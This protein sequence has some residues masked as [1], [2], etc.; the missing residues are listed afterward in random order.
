M[1]R[2]IKTFAVLLVAVIALFSFSV[3]AGATEVS[4]SQDGLV[5]S[6]ISAKD[7]Y[8]SNENIE[9]VFQVT[10]T[11]DFDVENVSLEAIIPDGLTL[12]SK[13]D[14]S[15]KT[16]SLKSG[17]SLKLDLIVVKENSVIVAPIET[18]APSV[19]STTVTQTESVQTATAKA[20]SNVSD[21]D[22]G[23][24]TDNTSIKTGSNMSCWLA[25]LICLVSLAVAV[26]AFRFRK[27]AVKYLSL[28]L[29]VCISVSTVAVVSVTNTMAEETKQRMSFEVSKTFTV[30]NVNYELKSVIS[31][32]VTIDLSTYEEYQVSRAIDDLSNFDGF[33]SLTDNEKASKYIEL[34]KDFSD[35]GLVRKDS[36]D[37][38]NGIVGFECKNGTQYLIEVEFHSHENEWYFISPST[39]SNTYVNNTAR[40]ILKS[41]SLDNSQSLNAVIMCD[42][43]VYGERTDIDNYY[44]SLV[45]NLENNGIKTSLFFNPTI[46][47]YKTALIN[48]DIIDISQ[49]GLRYKKST[50]LATTEIPSE[51][52]D[53]AYKEDLKKHRIIKEKSGGEYHYYISSKFFEYYY[54]DGRKLDDSIVF[55][56]SCYGF[57]E[58]GKNDFNYADS[59][60]KSG[61]KAVVGYNH[62]TIGNYIINIEDVTIC[63]LLKGNTIGDSI[64]T[65][66]AQCGLDSK[67]Y[68]EKNGL[69]FSEI[70]NYPIIRGN[71]ELKLTNKSM[72][73]QISGFVYEENRKKAINDV[74]VEVYNSDNK[75]VAGTSTGKYVSD[76]E[77]NFIINALSEGNYKFVFSKDG[78]K[79][80]TLDVQVKNGDDRVLI[81]DMEQNNGTLSGN[82]VSSDNSPISNVRVD[83]YLKLKSGKQFI[84]NTYT[85]DK[86]NFSMALQGG[87]YE[88]GFNKDGYKETVEGVE[89]SNGVMT[90]LKDPVVME[91]EDTYKEDF[92]NAILESE[93]N[94]WGG[95]NSTAVVIKF[96][97]LNFDGKPEFIV[98]F[99][100][101]GYSLSSTAPTAVLY[102]DNNNILKANSW[103]R[104]ND[105]L[106]GYYDK[107]NSRYFLLQSS[108]VFS[109][110]YDDNNN[111]DLDNYILNFDGND[112][113]QNIYSS[114]IHRYNTTDGTETNVYYD[115]ANEELSNSITKEEYDSI[116]SRIVENC[117]NVN[118][119]TDKI[120][121]WSTFKKYSDSE[122][123]EALEKAYESFT[124][125][126]Y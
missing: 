85:D 117:V 27:K 33:E 73:A 87:S 70:P 45:D 68:C 92:I 100:D 48:K 54:K 67:I 8:K 15:I 123:R 125:D 63:E 99:G 55:L 94:L 90:A 46:Q 102:Y 104:I 11:N 74:F 110:G 65:A 2:I 81:I 109:S 62:V 101:N 6:I 96:L 77:G 124:Y 50:I 24:N 19:E 1:K 93:G 47:N 79:E 12:K 84:D 111:W 38:D 53:K 58:N 16:V 41:L 4:N 75:I 108:K 66:K 52:T 44:N 25:G 23:N 51:T 80:K 20:N 57:G 98:Q 32:S 64:D 26:L 122:K 34:L 37:Y 17:E 18:T 119:Q 39:K 116:N 10:N 30:D 95:G 13:N 113:S 118:M 40:N 69:D 120:Y 43:Y 86:G 83:A 42:W 105:E 49:H 115:G 21:T 56:E 31:Y 35:K 60:I 91:K 114:M 7:N 72:A 89:I 78:Y 59:L 82:V 121:Y 71:S 36:I 107:V 97:D 28:V 9:L 112:V 61:A 88:L 5:A 22:K 3:T 29:C 14:T 76:N 103:C 106:A 126:K